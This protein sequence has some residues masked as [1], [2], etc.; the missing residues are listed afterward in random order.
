MYIFLVPT[1]S[2][3]FTNSCLP[4]REVG[5]LLLYRFPTGGIRE[6]G[7]LGGAGFV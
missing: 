3:A 5:R 4:G 2:R 6:D 1:R 7:I